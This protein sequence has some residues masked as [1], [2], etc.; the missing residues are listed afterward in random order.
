MAKPFTIEVETK[1]FNQHVTKFLA[2]Y[3]KVDTKVAV[4]KFAL[5]LLRKIVRKMPVDTGR[6]RAG[7]YPSMQGLGGMWTDRGGDNTEI[8]KGKSEG[9]FTVGTGHGSYWVELVNGVPYIIYLEYGHSRQAAYGMVRVSMR[10]MRKGKLP[11]DMAKSAQKEW[12]KFY[13]G[14]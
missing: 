7:W 13:Y 2:K 1:M 10:E 12:N 8:S 6:A 11:Q 4:R 9:D 14:A 5:D 3:N